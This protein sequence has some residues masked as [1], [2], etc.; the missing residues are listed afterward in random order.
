M[1]ARSSTGQLHAFRWNATSGKV[2][3]G[4]SGG[5]N[6]VA[7]AINHTGQIAGRIDTSSTTH[8][9]FWPTHGG[10]V[11]LGTLS[12]DTESEAYGNHREHEDGAELEAHVGVP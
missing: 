4:A 11:D 2:D 3:L 8:A 10:L 5:T 9:A 6:S 12:G 1:L 7:Y